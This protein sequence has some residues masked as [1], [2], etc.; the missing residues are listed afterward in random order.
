M[1]LSNQKEEKR[2]GIITEEKSIR[3]TML[4]FH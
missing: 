2:M 3:T 1:T 4:Y